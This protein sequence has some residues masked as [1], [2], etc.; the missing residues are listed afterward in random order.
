MPIF[1]SR[2]IVVLLNGVVVKPFT[3][4]ELTQ[5]IRPLQDYQFESP[6]IQWLF[7]ELLAFDENQRIQFI[8]F[9]TGSMA[10]P[11]G[12]LAELSPK[13]S[14]ARRLGNDADQVLPSVATCTGYVKLPEY[15]SRDVLREKL[16]LAISEGRQGF[17]LA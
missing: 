11:I 8:Q 7:E 16:L 1:T 15:S 9:V 6:Q 14:V 17:L 2:E 3:I 12:G 4:E 5:N 10:L 13:L